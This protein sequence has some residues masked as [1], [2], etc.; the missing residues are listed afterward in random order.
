M[1]LIPIIIPIEILSITFPDDSAGWM[2]GLR[3]CNIANNGNTVNY[4]AIIV[5]LMNNY[6]WY[7]FVIF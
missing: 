5:R 1:A 2:D 6:R 4:K 7:L 3:K